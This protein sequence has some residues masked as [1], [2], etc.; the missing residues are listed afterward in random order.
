M[1]SYTL[2]TFRNKGSTNCEEEGWPRGHELTSIGLPAMKD[3]DK[4]CSFSCLYVSEKGGKQNY[5]IQLMYPS[6]SY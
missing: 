5:W 6:N 1:Y 2:N 3:V 4:L